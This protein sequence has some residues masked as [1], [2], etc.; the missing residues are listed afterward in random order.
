MG[1]PSRG[2]APGAEISRGGFLGDQGPFGGLCSSVGAGVGRRRVRGRH[3][4]VA[5]GASGPREQRGLSHLRLVTAGSP[6]P[7]EHPARGAAA[8]CCRPALRPFAEGKSER[9]EGVG[10]SWDPFS[11]GSD[12]V[13]S[14][15]FASVKSPPRLQALEAFRLLQRDAWMGVTGPVPSPPLA[16][17]SSDSFLCSE[18]GNRSTNEAAY[19]RVHEWVRPRCSQNGFSRKTEIGSLPSS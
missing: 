9:R 3:A 7:A 12:A 13:T 1:F 6:R 5:S 17:L 11:H 19:A 14:G 16:H 4:D 18:T 2:R 8:A 15:R 10:K